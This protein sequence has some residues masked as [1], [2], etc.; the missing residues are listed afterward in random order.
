MT[1]DQTKKLIELQGIIA[2]IE[3]YETGYYNEFTVRARK[4]IHEL[5]TEQHPF[6]EHW[7]E[8]SV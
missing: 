3:T 1:T 4:L 5:L 6:A 2:D 8:E 7:Q